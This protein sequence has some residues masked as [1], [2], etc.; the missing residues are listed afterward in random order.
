MAVAA[1]FASRTALLLLLSSAGILLMCSFA[2][3][4]YLSHQLKFSYIEV[5]HYI[6]SKKNL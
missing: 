1:H 3:Q 5:S 6:E 2:S 4:E